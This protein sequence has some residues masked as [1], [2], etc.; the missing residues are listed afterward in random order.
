MCS[1]N[2]SRVASGP[3]DFAYSEH[4]NDAILAAAE[5]GERPDYGPGL[6]R[7]SAP[8]AGAKDGPLEWLGL[9]AYAGAWGQQSL[10]DVRQVVALAGFLGVP[11]EATPYNGIAGFAASGMFQDQYE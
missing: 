7:S 4:G 1:T 2:Y 6:Y 5:S 10:G 11:R 3:N 8:A 9:H